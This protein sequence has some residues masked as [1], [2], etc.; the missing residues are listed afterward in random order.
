M[1]RNLTEQQ[2]DYI[3]LTVHNLPPGCAEQVFDEISRAVDGVLA[4][5]DDLCTVDCYI[6]GDAGRRIY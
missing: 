4:R 5:Y 1:K 6:V 2:A 3:R